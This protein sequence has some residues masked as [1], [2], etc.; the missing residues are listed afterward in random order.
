MD[1]G[2]PQRAKL[3][4]LDPV[5]AGC[6]L[7]TGYAVVDPPHR[8]VSLPCSPPHVFYVSR[9]ILFVF[10]LRNLPQHSPMMYLN[11]PFFP[12]GQLYISSCTKKEWVLR[13]T[14]CHCCIDRSLRQQQRIIEDVQGRGSF[15]SLGAGFVVKHHAPSLSRSHGSSCREKVRSTTKGQR[16]ETFASTSSPTAWIGGNLTE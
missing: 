11:L 5:M 10:Q 7:L 3:A 4:L 15:R 9:T 16:V 2:R 8:L 13:D 12:G 1:L 6:P 14:R